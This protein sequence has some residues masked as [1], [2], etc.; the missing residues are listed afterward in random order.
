[1]SRGLLHGLGTPRK[2]HWRHTEG[3]P[4]ARGAPEV[5]RAVTIEYSTWYC[6]TVARSAA[7]ITVRSTLQSCTVVPGAYREQA[8]VD[9]EGEVLPAGLQHVQHVPGV[10]QLAGLA[11][12]R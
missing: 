5:H 10:R 7:S 1:M 4:R 11:I 3:T 8:V 6:T 9:G 2:V 12:D